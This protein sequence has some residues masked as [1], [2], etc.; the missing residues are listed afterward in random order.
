MLERAQDLD[1]KQT[2]QGVHDS[3]TQV[4]PELM[5]HLRTVILQSLLV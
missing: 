4:I 1:D 5:V 3:N 2:T